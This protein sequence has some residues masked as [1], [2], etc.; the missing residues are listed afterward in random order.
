MSI[1]QYSTDPEELQKFYAEPDKRQ[2]DAHLE[3]RPSGAHGSFGNLVVRAGNVKLQTP[4]AIP[5]PKSRPTWASQR[6]QREMMCRDDSGSIRL[7]STR[8]SKG[9]SRCQS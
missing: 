2:P 5:A 8:S 4:R 9:K 6:C 7:V 1:K 3:R